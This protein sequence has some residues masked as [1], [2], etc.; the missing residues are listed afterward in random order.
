MRPLVLAVPLLVSGLVGTAL[1]ACGDD[2]TPSGERRGSYE[3]DAT[4]DDGGATDARTPD[5]STSGT[6]GAAATDASA[7]DGSSDTG[8]PVL[9]PI[10]C[11]MRQFLATSG[12][13]P[14]LESGLRAATLPGGR[15]LVMWN[16]QP[17][18]SQTRPSYRIYDGATWRPT[19]T[20]ASDGEIRHL[21]VDGLGNAYVVY[22]PAGQSKLSRAVLAA[23]S[24]AF[25]AE[26]LIDVDVAQEPKARLS[27]LAS[28]SLLLY[29]A[30][31]AYLASRYDVATATWGAP[32]TLESFQGAAV[33][34]LGV[35]TTNKA[36]AVWLD[37]AGLHLRTFD[38]A[39][40]AAA[41]LDPV[42]PV[43]PV[44]HQP[45]ATVL[46]NGD[47]YTMWIEPGPVTK[48]RGHLFHV[49]TQT[50]DALNALYDGTPTYDLRNELRV[51]AND[52]LTATFVA[53]P[54][55]KV[56]G[57]FVARNIGAGWSTTS[58]GGYAPNPV[59]DRFGNV[60]LGSASVV[61]GKGLLVRVAAASTTLLASTPTT[62]SPNFG[63]GLE[64]LALALDGAN[65][66]NV[67]ALEPNGLV[68][69][70]CK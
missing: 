56:A 44:A 62:L 60:Y 25:G 64:R 28:G 45:S 47:V 36:A 39:T 14:R 63:D 15:M 48:V 1:V 6:D 16:G 66:A 41:V 17:T 43:A 27:G 59:L 7:F 50:W 67:F 34:R 37:A 68:T 55:G 20:F 19:L 40:W 13:G 70:V 69:A 57:I 53:E 42:A 29:R 2:A 5:S 54:P 32:I 52:H 11:G 10:A 58:F 8:P 35:G 49:A 38:G 9:G 30:A 26:D 12:A 51:D 31:D 65:H 46:S 24:A 22:Q 21:S 61:T 23:G 33:G 4:F 18:A 3:G